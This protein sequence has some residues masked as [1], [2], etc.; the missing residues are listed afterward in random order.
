MLLSDSSDV[1]DEAS[2]YFCIDDDPKYRKFCTT[3][4]GALPEPAI[5]RD[6][7]IDHFVVTSRLRVTIKRWILTKL[8]N[9]RHAI[10]SDHNRIG[11]TAAIPISRNTGHSGSRAASHARSRTWESCRTCLRAAAFRYYTIVVYPWA[12]A[13]RAR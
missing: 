5:K 9:K 11:W 10:E 4:S 8:G 2:S 13:S 1:E 7:F 12:Q 3:P 6:F